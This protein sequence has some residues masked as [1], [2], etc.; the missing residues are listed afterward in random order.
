LKSQNTRPLLG[1]YVPQCDLAGDY[2]NKQCHSSTGFCWCVDVET[3]KE[4]EG[5]KK[6]GELDCGKNDEKN[7]YV[8]LTIVLIA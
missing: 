1:A 8:N 7:V 3:G 5:T 6:R 2:T 4:I